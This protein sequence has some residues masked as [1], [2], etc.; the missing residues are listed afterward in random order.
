MS[1]ERPISQIEIKKVG[2]NKKKRKLR[3]G[4]FGCVFPPHLFQATHFFL[5]CSFQRKISNFRNVCHYIYPQCFMTLF[6]CT[7]DITVA[8]AITII[9][10]KAST[11]TDPAHQGR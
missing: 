2:T 5:L 10:A 6:K 8:F 3:F 4:P 1:P 11:V 9:I 7:I